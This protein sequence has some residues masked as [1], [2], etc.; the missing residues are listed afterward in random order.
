MNIAFSSG[1]R[2]VLDI[3]IN[4][5]VKRCFYKIQ[6]LVYDVIVHTSY[7]KYFYTNRMGFLIIWVRIYV[8]WFDYYMTR[9]GTIHCVGLK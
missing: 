2:T 1:Q 4:L 9:Y 7:D 8:M 6:T 3:Q 5:S